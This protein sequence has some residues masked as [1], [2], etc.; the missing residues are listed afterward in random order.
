MKQDEE[1]DEKVRYD[2][3]SSRL[4]MCMKKRNELREKLA[5]SKKKTSARGK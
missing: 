5:L 2:I 4:Q 3:A 1:K